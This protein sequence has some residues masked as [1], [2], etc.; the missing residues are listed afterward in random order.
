MLIV[1]QS[2]ARAFGIVGVASLV[3]YRA[4]VDDPKDAGVMLANLGIGLAS[5]VGLYLIAAFATVFLLGL[6]VVGRVVRAERA[7]ALPAERAGADA[8]GAA[9]ASSRRCCGATARS[10][11]CARSPVRRSR[12]EVRLPFDNGPRSSRRDDG[13][14][15]ARQD[16]RRVG[17]EEEVDLRTRDEPARASGRRP[18][19]GGERAAQGEAVGATSRSSAATCGRS[20]RRSRTPSRAASRCTR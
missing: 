2:L 19:R 3:R 15:R 6:P 10:S 17:R 8:R 4:K 9:R 5:G 20:R 14:R 7:Q 13:A 16:R 1:G 11:T 18:Q 12:Y